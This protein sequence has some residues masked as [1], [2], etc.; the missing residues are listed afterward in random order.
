MAKYLKKDVSVKMMG[1]TLIGTTQKNTGILSVRNIIINRDTKMLIAKAK[2]YANIEAFNTKS[3]LFEVRIKIAGA[4][5]DKYVLEKP[6][7][8][9]LE[10]SDFITM[11]IYKF[12]KANVNTTIPPIGQKN[13]DD[14][15][16]N[17]DLLGRFVD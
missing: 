13:P 14:V 4:D 3:H 16:N 5:F 7:S 2:V 12:L 10:S 8:D 11:R 1:V 15:V 6:T 17:W 9:E